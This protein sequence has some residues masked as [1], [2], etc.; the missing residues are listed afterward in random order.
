MRVAAQVVRAL[1]V[2]C[3]ADNATATEVGVLHARH[4]S[5]RP[6]PIAPQP[7]LAILARPASGAEACSVYGSP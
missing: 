4:K 7:R 6:P 2:R 1:S 3:P 5:P